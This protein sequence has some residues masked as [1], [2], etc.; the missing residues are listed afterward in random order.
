[1]S[2]RIYGLLG[3][4]LGHSFSV[5]LHHSLGNTDYKLIELSPDELGDFLSR[6]D[7]GG[8]N[9]TIPY[10]RDVMP[11]CSYIDPAAEEIGAVNTIVNRAGKLCAYNTDKYGFEYAVRRAGIDFSG[12]KAVIFGSGGTSRTAR[13][14]ARSLGAGEI[15]VISRHGENNYDNLDRHSD[16]GII[17]NTTPVGMFPNCPAAP[18]SLSMFPNCSGVMDVVYNPLRT[19][20]TME[21]ERLGIP[22][23][24]GL[25]MLAAQAKAAEELFFDRTI[26]DGENERLTKE[27]FLDAVNIVIIGM[28]GSG[29]TTVGKILSKQTGRPLVDM[30][31]YITE[32]VG[33]SPSNLIKTRGEAAFRKIE[34]DALRE[35]SKVGGQIITT[36]GGVVVVPENY[37]LLHQNG[38]IYCLRRSLE[39]LAT[40]DRPLST[41]LEGL[42][43]MYSVR[44]PLYE[45]FADVLIDN[46]GTLSS[47]VDKILED[48]NENTRY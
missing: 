34:H 26:D 39:K 35:V 16:A 13:A 36:G 3:E 9:V 8:L 10:K 18:A 4:K 27:L 5:P 38:R 32:K 22:C 17:I 33:V 47:A 24:G 2:G 12:K 48:F 19:G 7:I 40:A 28:P 31:K 6:E 43:A 23:S 11:Y 44:R 25:Y 21:A 45:G 14:A 29:K 1:M 41:G 20:L 46:N 37:P 30:D 42:K 15:V